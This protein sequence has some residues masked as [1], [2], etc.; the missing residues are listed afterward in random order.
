MHGGDLLG[1]WSV[2]KTVGCS[3]RTLATNYSDCHPTVVKYPRWGSKRKI[4]GIT[5]LRVV[6]APQSNHFLIFLHDKCFAW[7]MEGEVRVHYN[8]D[9]NFH[10][11]QLPGRHFAWWEKYDPQHILKYVMK[12]SL[13]FSLSLR[14]MMAHESTKTRTMRYAIK[15]FSLLLKS[16]HHQGLEGAIIKKRLFV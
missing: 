1:W 11:V 3:G 2:F 15:W 13:F 16:I 5:Y 4:N 10:I 12:N 7:D 6:V 14:L 9:D 8:F